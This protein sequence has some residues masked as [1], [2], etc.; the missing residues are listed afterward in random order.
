[1]VHFVSRMREWSRLAS[2]V[3]IAF[4]IWSWPAAAAPRASAGTM[5]I[6]GEKAPTRGT[7]GGNA[8]RGGAVSV[9]GALPGNRHKTAAPVRS[10]RAPGAAAPAKGEKPASSGPARPGFQP[11]V[12]I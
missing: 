12:K 6:G 1:M 2:P 11:R 3:A 10:V 4:G 5:A 7:I 9:G 8:P